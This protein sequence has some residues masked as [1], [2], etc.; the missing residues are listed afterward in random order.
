MNQDGDKMADI[1]E[2]VRQ[3]DYLVDPCAVADALLRRLR[4]RAA[5]QT[6]Y[7]VPELSTPALIT[8]NAHTQ[9]VRRVHP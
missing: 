2:R 8:L 3:G 5:A 7:A 9:S 1:K 6:L 4:E